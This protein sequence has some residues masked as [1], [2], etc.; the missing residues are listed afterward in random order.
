MRIIALLIALLLALAPAHSGWADPSPQDAATGVLAVTAVVGA[1]TQL[2]TRAGLEVRVEVFRQPDGKPFRLGHPTALQQIANGGI[3]PATALID[4]RLACTPYMQA[5]SR[6]TNTL[7]DARTK[8]ENTLNRFE[9]PVPSLTQIVAELDTQIQAGNAV[10]AAW[11]T[12]SIACDSLGRGT[13]LGSGPQ[14]AAQ[15][16]LDRV[17]GPLETLATIHSA[18]DRP[19]SIDLIQLSRGKIGDLILDS[20]PSATREMKTAASMKFVATATAPGIPADC[21]HQREV[22][23]RGYYDAVASLEAAT[24]QKI[25]EVALY[26]P[27]ADLLDAICLTTGPATMAAAE[28]QRNAG[29]SALQI[30]LRTFLTAVNL[31][32]ISNELIQQL[33]AQSK[34]ID[35]VTDPKNKRSWERFA[36]AQSRAV[37]GDENAVVYLEDAATP[38]LKSATFDPSKFIE[39]NAK[40]FQVAFTSATNLVGLPQPGDAP[41]DTNLFDLKKKKRESQSQLKSDQMAFRAALLSLMGELANEERNNTSVAAALRTAATQLGAGTE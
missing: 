15:A 1:A 3:A 32:P 30:V 23:R 9:K 11:K 33:L 41:T 17:R 13:E 14:L 27:T 19:L 25:D 28:E 36:V 40:M 10:L 18:A 20:V 22:L 7:I 37:M 31:G 29:R 35:V 4:T 39:A 38:V 8:L 5:I 6:Q 12:F 24:N 34:A 16:A 26:Q 21:A 2:A